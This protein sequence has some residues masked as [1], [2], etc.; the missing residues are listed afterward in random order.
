MTPH[1]TDTLIEM[2]ACKDAVKW[3]LDYDTLP[4]AWKACKDGSRMDWLLEK[5]GKWTPK[6]RATYE[7][8]IGPAG[9][10]YEAVRDQAWATYQAT[11][12]PAYA[13]YEA[14]ERPAFATYQAIEGTALATYEAIE[15]PAGATYEAECADAIRALYPNPP[16]I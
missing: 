6:K 1:F 16:T 5:T 7:A 12:G 15:G 9:A 13:T 3:C 4:E 2:N 11:I 10:T 8:T 14:I